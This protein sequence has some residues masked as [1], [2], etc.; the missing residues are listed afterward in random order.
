MQKIKNDSRV[1]RCEGLA[2]GNALIQET[3]KKVSA[4]SVTKINGPFMCPRCLSEAIV[5]KC[6]EKVDHF[7][8][9]ARLSPIISSGESALHKQVK[10]EILSLFRSY[11]P[12]GNWEAERPIPENLSKKLKAVVPDISGRTNQ[13]SLIRDELL[14][15]AL[16]IQKTPYT[17]RKIREKT[18]NYAKRGIF[19][20]WIVPLKNKLGSDFF[21]PRLYEKYLHA[22][23]YGRVYY[24]V[25]NA[26]KKLI[27]VHFSPAK[28]WVEEN[29]WFDTD[30]MEERTEGGFYLTYKT[31]KEPNYA[32]QINLK[33]LKPT[34]NNGFEGKNSE[35]NVPEFLSYMDLLS[36]WWP[37]DEYKNL[38]KQKAVVQ[39]SKLFSEYEFYDDY[40]LDDFNSE[41]L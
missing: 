16:E 40:D 34:K 41:E 31:V 37:S 30:L 36:K 8:H 12:D 17:V 38:D 21:R 14:P 20:L 26:D 18:I 9:K 28:R 13:K 22:M 15:V 6:T 3:L 1:A 23:Y 11:Y 7:A 24:Y 29:T 25:P 2:T 19:V 33:N 39:W 27:P 10:E 5:R 4:S 35:K 32:P